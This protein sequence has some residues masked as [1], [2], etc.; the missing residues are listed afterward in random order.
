MFPVSSVSVVFWGAG[1]GCTQT[2]GGGWRGGWGGMRHGLRA[3]YELEKAHVSVVRRLCACVRVLASLSLSLSLFL[4]LS[5]SLSVLPCLTLGSTCVPSP[6]ANT[7]PPARPPRSVTHFTRIHCYCC[8]C[9]R[10]RQRER[11]CDRERE[12]EASTR[13]RARK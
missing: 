7:H 5:L 10:E 1:N 8:Y 3:P 4:S 11:A 12:R 13:T 9:C 6:H 2:T